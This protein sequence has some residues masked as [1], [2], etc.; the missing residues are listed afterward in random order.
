[1]SYGTEADQILTANVAK[2]VEVMMRKGRK[3]KGKYQAI[4]NQSVRKFTRSDKHECEK[5]RKQENL[6]SLK[7]KTT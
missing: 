2:D 5:V 7:K 6:T 1:M 4:I 3:M